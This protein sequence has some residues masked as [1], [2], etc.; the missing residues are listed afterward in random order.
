MKLRGRPVTDLCLP[1][2][3]EAF[4]RRLIANAIRRDGRL[5]REETDVYLCTYSNLYYGCCWTMNHICPGCGGRWTT[6]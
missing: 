4:V 3:E 5:N 6:E 1:G 2:E